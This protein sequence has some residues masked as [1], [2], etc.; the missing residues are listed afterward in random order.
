MKARFERNKILRDS[1]RDE[2]LRLKLMCWMLIAKWSSC[3]RELQEKEDQKQK[4]FMDQLGVDLSKGFDSNFRS[5][6]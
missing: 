3:N 5:E 2:R 1:K 4:H 6:P